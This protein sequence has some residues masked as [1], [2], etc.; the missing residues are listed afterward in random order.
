MAALPTPANQT[1]AVNLYFREKAFWQFSRGFRLGDLR[2]L[3]RQYKRT[4]YQVF[5]VGTFF[6]NGNP[7]YGTDV[8]FPVVR[9]ST[10]DEGANP[11]FHGCIDRSA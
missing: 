2:R 9:T 4:Q 8:N 3:I 5:P 11:N 6:K 7:P 1:D 10:I